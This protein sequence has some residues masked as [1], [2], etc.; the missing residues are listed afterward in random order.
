[1]SEESKTRDFSNEDLQ[2]I[3]KALRTNVNA[4][5]ATETLDLTSHIV[6]NQVRM[7]ADKEMLHNLTKEVIHYGKLLGAEDAIERVDYFDF[8]MEVKKE[9]ITDENV[10]RENNGNSFLEASLYSSKS[11]EVI[12]AII[13][14][15][16]KLHESEE[17]KDIGWMLLSRLTLDYNNQLKHFGENSVKNNLGN[18]AVLIESG[19]IEK[20]KELEQLI[21]NPEL[22]EKYP[23]IMNKLF[24]G[25]KDLPAK[26]ANVQKRG[27]LKE[28]K[29]DYLQNKLTAV[30]AAI[31][32]HRRTPRNDD[33]A[34]VVPRSY[35][36]GE[37]GNSS[38]GKTNEFHQRV[39]DVH[40]IGAKRIMK[41]HLEE[42]QGR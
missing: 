15:G 10:N 36:L 40:M 9:H 14:K 17:P 18:L 6:E 23:D 42:K 41:K 24:E 39:A 34:I 33:T 1:M 13:D 38:T 29:D 7:N 19:L 12:Q 2:N 3:S 20:S 27:E 16:G 31:R 8:Y 4:D 37:T 21:S 11:P 32:Q 5:N 35:S 22:F 28:Q 26:L 25:D 30:K